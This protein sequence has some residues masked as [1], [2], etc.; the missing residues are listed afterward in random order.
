MVKTLRSVVRLDDVKSTKV[1]HIY[2]IRVPEATELENGN[3]VKLGDFEA[4]NR[5][6]RAGLTTTSGDKVVLIAATPLI[7]DNNRYKD[8]LEQYYY[9]EEGEVVRAYELGVTDVFSVSLKG[10]VDEPVVGSVIVP[11]GYKLDVLA[12]PLTAPTTGFVAKVIGIETVGGALS[13]N[14]TNSGTTL[15]KLEVTQV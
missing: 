7:Y 3:V 13:L 15:Y 10:F 8:G 2:N 5:D 4:T 11:N 9:A 14:V 1:G 6:V 12:D